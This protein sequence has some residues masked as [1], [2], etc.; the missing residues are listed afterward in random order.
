MLPVL[1]QR[2][3]RYAL[4]IRSVGTEWL[5]NQLVYLDRLFEFLGSPRTATELF[6]KLKVATITGFLIDYAEQYGPGSRRN[7]H[8]I[9]RAFLHFAYEEGFMASDLAA[10]VPTIRSTAK[11]RLP[12]CLPEESIVALERGIDRSSARG[13]RDAAIVCLLSTYGVRGVQIRRL[14]LEDI[15]WERSQIR[16]R[17]AKG[18]RPILQ[19]LT[20]KA[21]NRLADYLLEGR[22]QSACL[23]ARVPHR[24]IAPIQSISECEIS[25]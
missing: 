20:A 2:Y 18:G 15:D 8:K 14:C 6:G 4:T 21:G 13:R 11:A 7:M 22:P 5:E 10:L 12:R 25:A 17:A 16:F 23:H 3:R 1:R 24:V 19:H 9:F